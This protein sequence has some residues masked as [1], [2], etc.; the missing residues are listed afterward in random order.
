MQ[1]LIIGLR[2][3]LN[4]ESRGNPRL[5]KW[6]ASLQSRYVSYCE[7]VH[8]ARNAIVWS[9]YELYG[10][11]AAREAAWPLWPRVVAT[12][13]TAVWVMLLARRLLRRARDRRFSTGTP[14]SRPSRSRRAVSLLPAVIRAWRRFSFRMFL[15]PRPAPLGRLLRQ[16]R[17]KALRLLEAEPVRLSGIGR[18]GGRTRPMR[19]VRP[20]SRM[21][22]PSRC[23]RSRLRRHRIC[24]T[25]G[26][27]TMR[28]PPPC[29]CTCGT[30]PSSQGMP[31]IEP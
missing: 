29:P 7:K 9:Y 25:C 19:L 20:T 21:C 14:A 26:G 31:C 1:A 23:I 16:A 12:L 8:R 15:G 6:P 10:W 2:T 5:G 13:L 24:R 28:R 18:A 11:T 4:A 3:D 27:R 22:S 30:C 17:T